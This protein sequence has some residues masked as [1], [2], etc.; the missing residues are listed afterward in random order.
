M[1]PIHLYPN[2][3]AI[4]RHIERI[5]YRRK[6]CI[7]YLTHE[8]IDL[9]VHTGQQFIA[10]FGLLGAGQSNNIIMVDVNAPRWLAPMPF[11][12]VIGASRTLPIRWPRCG[13]QRTRTTNEITGGICVLIWFDTVFADYSIS[14]VRPK[15]H[16]LT[17]YNF[18]LEFGN[19]EIPISMVIVDRV[20][21]CAYMMQSTEQNFC[22][23]TTNFLCNT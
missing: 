19:T 12:T 18:R 7:A 10:P 6:V 5:E 22:V 9:S 13:T 1:N 8:R 11:H 15:I 3:V 21:V 4:S 16:R 23:Q 20:C 14:I 2:T 17:K